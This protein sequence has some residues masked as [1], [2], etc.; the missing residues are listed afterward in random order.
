MNTRTC[1][2]ALTLALALNSAL[3]TASD[4]VPPSFGT[5]LEALLQWS[6][7]HS[8]MIA[9]MQAETEARRQQVIMARSLDDPMLGVEW[10]D[11]DS[12]S[13]TLNPVK[14]G[15]MRYTVSQMLPLWGKRDLKGRIA[16]ANVGQAE[17]GVIATRADLRQQIRLAWAERYSALKTQ[18][19]N[20]EIEGLLLQMEQAARQRYQTGQGAQADLI[21]LQT[22]LSMLR[23]EQLLLSGK[24]GRA[25][26]GLAALL[27]VPLASL[28]GQPGELPTA[29]V[30]FQPAA[31]VDKALVSNP[32]LVAARQASDS[33]RGQRDLAGLN[34][35]PGVTVGL[36]AI[37]MESRLT[38]YELMLEVQIPLQRA[39]KNAERAEAVAMLSRARAQE[40]AQLRMVERE[41]NEMTVML[42]TAR[43]QAALLDS[44]LLP[45]AEL[46]FQS[47]LAGYQNGRGEFAGLLETQ[48]QI[49]RLRQMRLMADIDQFQAWTGLLKLAGDQ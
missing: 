40:Q 20:G 19:I 42:T 26:A 24:A 4:A 6:E 49:R 44:T 27:N 46:G 29:P 3:A 2:Q 28:S 30:D 45:Q 11:I 36:S 21:R 48:Q 8:P 25:A 38:M 32:E 35:R 10:R 31:W 12:D 22:E 5:S 33:A 23:N 43:A 41:V 18:A 34:T 17:Q 16:E 14:V 9:A 7:T 39:A 37:Q 13:P 47:T 1:L 15:S